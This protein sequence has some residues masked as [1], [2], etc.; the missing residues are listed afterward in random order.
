MRNDSQ[1]DGKTFGSVRLNALVGEE[2][3]FG[4][5]LGVPSSKPSFRLSAPGCGGKYLKVIVS[6]RVNVGSCHSGLH[7]PPVGV[8]IGLNEGFLRQ[9]ELLFQRRPIW[10]EKVF[11]DSENIVMGIS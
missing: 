6:V 7:I 11:A 9:C 10:A 2:E 5:V 8:F 1:S 4:R 3:V